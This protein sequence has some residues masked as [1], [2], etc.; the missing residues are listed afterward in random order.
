MEHRTKDD[1]IAW[2]LELMKQTDADLI[3]VFTHALLDS[4]LFN[5]EDGDLLALLH[6][7][8]LQ[9]AIDWLEAEAEAEV[10]APD[11]N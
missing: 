1:M 2:I 5:W 6:P 11:E 4:P 7:A 9:A 10:Q 8:L 3:D